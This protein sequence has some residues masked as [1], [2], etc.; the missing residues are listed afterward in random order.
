MN[1]YETRIDSSLR[2]YT[3]YQSLLLYIY[4][5][6]R[7]VQVDSGQSCKRPIGPEYSRILP[8]SGAGMCKHRHAAIKSTIVRQYSSIL[9]TAAESKVRK[10]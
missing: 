8:A 2:I 7:I 1:F 9:K 3:M 5:Y 10:S 4:N 6:L